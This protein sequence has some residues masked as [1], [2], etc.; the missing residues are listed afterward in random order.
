MTFVR[1]RVKLKTSV[2]KVE[3]FFIFVMFV[4]VSC[5][6]NSCNLVAHHHSLKQLKFLNAE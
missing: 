3:M 4:K 2:I 1:L 6:K 5:T